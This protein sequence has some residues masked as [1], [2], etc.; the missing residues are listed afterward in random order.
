MAA[1]AA[2]FSAP[3]RSGVTARKI[4]PDKGSAAGVMAVVLAWFAYAYTIFFLRRGQGVCVC[5][6]RCF[7]FDRFGREHMKNIPFGRGA[8][9]TH[10]HNGRLD[11][12]S[13]KVIIHCAR[14]FFSVGAGVFVCV[15]SLAHRT[16]T[17]FFRAEIINYLIT[18]RRQPGSAFS[19]P[20]ASCGGGGG[21]HCNCVRALRSFPIGS[22]RL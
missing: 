5:V 21:G 11:R 7:D 9:H 17:A 16:A 15:R 18:Q 13:T 6:P 4:T 10:T 8:T 19:A 20:G 2:F 1:A 3:P 22:H 14:A 12:G